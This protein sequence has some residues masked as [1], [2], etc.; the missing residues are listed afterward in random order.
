MNN[1][2]KEAELKEVKE[3]LLISDWDCPNEKKYRARVR[4]PQ[5]AI[6]AMCVICMGGSAVEVAHCTKINCVLYPFRMGKNPFSKAKGNA[7]AL[8]KAR[9]QQTNEVTNEQRTI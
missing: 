3:N 4:N 6:R 8:R 9:E 5:T 2:D 7:E 1:E